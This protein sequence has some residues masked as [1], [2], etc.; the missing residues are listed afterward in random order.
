[1]INLISPVEADTIFEQV[2][3]R[4]SKGAE[5]RDEPVVVVYESHEL[6]QL[7]HILWWWPGHD[8][9]QLGIEG[10]DDT[11]GHQVPTEL[12]RGLEEY[13]FLLLQP[14]AMVGQSGEDSPEISHMLLGVSRVDDDVVNVHFTAVTVGLQHT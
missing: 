4:G 11:V 2:S 9:L 10:A 5:T 8:D 6:A 13:T 3:Q 1:M 12:R 14:D 7:F